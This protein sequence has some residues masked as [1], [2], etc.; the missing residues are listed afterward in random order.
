[1]SGSTGCVLRYFPYTQNSPTA[2]Y[3]VD[4][5]TAVGFL[6][7]HW[8]TDVLLTSFFCFAEHCMASTLGAAPLDCSCRRRRLFSEDMIV[9]GGV[10]FSRSQR[11]YTWPTEDMPRW[12][13]IFRSSTAMS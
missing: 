1:V 6:F 2:K 3:A 11:S 13:T 8:N 4:S 10:Q 5:K 7:S 12:A 9:G